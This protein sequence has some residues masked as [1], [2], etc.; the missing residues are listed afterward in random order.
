[1]NDCTGLLDCPCADCVDANRQADELERRLALLEEEDPA[2]MEE[3]PAD[4]W[5]DDQGDVE[6]WEVNQLDVMEDNFEAQQAQAR[7]AA[8]AT[9][10]DHEV[11]TSGLPQRVVDAAGAVVYRGPADGGFGGFARVLPQAY[12]YEYDRR[13]T[14][15][16][17]RDWKQRQ[18]PGSK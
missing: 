11:R 17:Y 7:N 10:Y 3:D 15:K 14:K 8:A 6:P 4:H 5:A 9:V 13:G 1:M 16:N 2:P 12:E 18:F